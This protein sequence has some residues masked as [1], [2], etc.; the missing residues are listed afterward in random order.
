[1]TTT[2]PAS[3][4]FDR[5]LLVPMVLGSIL[6][7]VNSSLIAVALVPIGIALGAPATQTAWLVSGLYLATAVGQ[8]VT[9][10]LVDIYGPRPLFLV[11]TVLV[12]VGGALGVLAPGIA[13][14][15]VARVVIGLGTCAGY[16]AAM[17]LVR[18]EAERTGRDSPESVLTVLSVSAQTIV[19]IGP[20]LGGLLIAVGGWR[21]TF[22]V[23]IPLAIVSLASGWWL[24]PRSSSQRTGPVV[25]LIDPA[26]IALFAVTLVALLLFL[27]RPSLAGSPLLVVTAAAAAGLAWW[28]RRATTPFL[29]VRVLAG[30]TPLLL[31]FLRA[32]LAAVVS[33]SVFYGLTQWLEQGRG[34]APTVAG[35]VLLPMFLSGI[36]VSALTGRRRRIRRKL[37]VGAAVQILVPVLMLFLGSTSAIWLLVL[38]GLLT[39]IPQG[40]TNLAVQNAVYRQADPRRTASSAGLLRT[41]L[42]LGAI[43]AGTS[44]GLAYAHGVTTPGLHV[45]ALVMLA[46][47][48][49]FAL[50][51]L[52]DRSLVDLA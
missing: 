37:L 35:F 2:E 23:D 45:L 48:G 17:A 50:I 29:D 8:P 27:E 31:T 39:G 7:P 22:A 10:R 43:A 14:L 38:V 52:L 6:N 44:G 32:L 46:A 9:G 20:A 36:A 34:L 40:L 30:N 12:G 33:Y 49:A 15:V 26:G 25:S 18:R 5:R 42:Y 41:F 19:V 47:A 4:A 3:R 21:A 13:I 16:P 24:L 1:M 11:G 51:T 28:E